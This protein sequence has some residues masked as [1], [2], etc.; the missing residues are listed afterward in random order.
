MAPTQSE[1]DEK[2]NSCWVAKF[3]SLLNSESLD[4]DLFR[5]YSSTFF[6]IWGL[7]KYHSK[8]IPWVNPIQVL[9]RVYL[10]SQ[11][12]VKFLSFE[13]VYT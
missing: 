7:N 11:V 13:L 10:H 3:G 6:S 2:K 12:L 5:I 1:P 9:Q 8:Q 4:F